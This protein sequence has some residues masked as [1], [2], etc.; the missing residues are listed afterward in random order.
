MEGKN[1]LMFIL[2]NIRRALRASSE[3]LCAI[4][5]T[6]IPGIIKGLTYLRILRNSRLLL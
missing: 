3:P 5:M 2:V 6:H 1:F 4:V